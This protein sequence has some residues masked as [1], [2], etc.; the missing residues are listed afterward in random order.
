M[1]GLSPERSTAAQVPLVGVGPPP[2]I[3]VL[4]GVQGAMTASPGDPVVIKFFTDVNANTSR[5]L[6]QVLDSCIVAGV[7]DLT[8]LISTTGGTVHDGVTL[9]NFIRGLEAQV[10]T[11]NFGSV[12][13]IGVPIFAAGKTRLSVP[14]ARF[15]I[16]RVGTTFLAPAGQVQVSEAQLTQTLK[17]L[18]ADEQNIAKIISA[19]SHRTVSQVLATMKAQPT[20]FPEQMKKWGLVHS[21]EDVS[22][23]I[24]ARLFTI[25]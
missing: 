23:P 19:N 5:Q 4:P 22:I 15:L 16:H 10:T 14:Q 13:S 24:G 11:H 1:T 8:L 7:T 25:Q 12:D 20:L 6:M 3:Q 21:I 18:L 17:S 2:G 9:Y